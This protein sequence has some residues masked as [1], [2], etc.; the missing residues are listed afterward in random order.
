MFKPQK[1][2]KYPEESTEEVR[3]CAAKSIVG[4]DNDNAQWLDV[5]Q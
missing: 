4:G 1:K 5:G 2:G 3:E